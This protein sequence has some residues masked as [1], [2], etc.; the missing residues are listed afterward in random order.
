[1]LV[2]RD[3]R[4]GG[5]ERVMVRL[6]NYAAGQGYSTHLVALV[7]GGPLESEID[8]KVQVHNLA[9][10]RIRSAVIPFFKLVGRLGPQAVMSTIPQANALT[11]LVTRFMTRRPRVVLR[12]ANDPRYE[13]PFSRRFLAVKRWLLGAVYRRADIVVAVSSG[14][15]AG[16]EQ[17]LG[18]LPAKIVTIPNASLDDTI[19]V[20]ARER[21]ADEW[22]EA[23]E[24]RVVCVARFTEQK[25]QA[26][27][28]AAF[29]RLNDLPKAG[30]V[31]IGHG[32]LGPALR[33]SIETMQLT[34]RVKLVTEE[35][36][37]FRWMKSANVVVLS[38]RWEGSP[39]VLIEAMALG[40]PVVSTDCPSGPS[41]L[42]LGGRLGP[43][44]PVGDA[45]ALAQAIRDT[46][47]NPT[48]SADLEARAREFHIRSVG[49]Q[50]LE[51]ALGS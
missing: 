10:K 40:T 44:V 49:P 43:L 7:G 13:M 28:L 30:L 17:A 39:N 6:A 38:S 50:W 41:E 22:Y 27:L 31:L 18:V 24:A 4:V 5:A 1:M 37:P 8:A 32:P 2:V 33:A 45:K 20:R 47:A 11:V 48:P 46:L 12:E 14:V 29:N 42:L 35:Q 3:L 21:V 19:Y 25:D 34:H 36:N 15:K 23:L 26:T 9:S 16:V 51:V